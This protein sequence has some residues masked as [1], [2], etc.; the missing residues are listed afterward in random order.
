VNIEKV[1]PNY[2]IGR[3]KIEEIAKVLDDKALDTVIFNNNL[4]PA[5]QR[6]I[7]DVFGKKVIDRTQLILDIF[8]QRARTSEGKIQV[9][10]AQLN[11]LLPRLTGKGIMLSRLG[12]GIGTRGPGE[13]KLEMDR[14][15]IRERIRR[16]NHEIEDVSRRRDIERKLRKERQ[17]P[18]IAVVGY[19]NAGK[20]TLVN[21]LSG[22][23]IFVEDKL[24]STLDPTTRK[25][26]VSGQNQFLLT[27]TVGFIKDL[28]S[29]LIAAFRATLEEIVEADAIVHLVDIS[30]LKARE[31]EAITRG[32][33]V[34]LGAGDK[35]TLL[36]LN[37]IDKL[38][39][40]ER[41][42]AMT[43][44]SDALAISARTGEGLKELCLR[45]SGLIGD[46]KQYLKVSIP[47]SEGRL[48]WE[49]HEEG[50]IIKKTCENGNVLIEAK[51]ERALAERLKPYIVQ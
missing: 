44:F 47:Q 32:F 4:G 6:N 37:K 49:L 31:M 45:L 46:K 48:L 51:V 40:E 7:E 28:P 2:Y 15:R 22:S 20:S 23:D 18:R 11:Y 39:A 36:A 17:I 27:D 41:R 25:V 35:K 24:F 12:G 9:E 21:T 5:Q 34:E 8:S 16:L 19:T 26:A 30:H 1:T 38:T 43:E 29:N 33:L 13:T 50:A 42:S 10:L 3:G 14:R